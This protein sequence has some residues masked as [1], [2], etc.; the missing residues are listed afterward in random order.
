MTSFLVD[1]IEKESYYG[2]VEYKL[3]FFNMN[4]QKIK[5]YATQMK[6]RLIEGY[7][8]AVYLIGVRDN[9]QIVGLT[10]EEIDR[11]KKMLELIAKEIDS[12]VVNSVVINV[13]NSSQRILLANIKAEFD[14]NDILL[15]N[16]NI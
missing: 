3:N 4:D 6:F 2:N 9:G 13:E 5:K 14:L 10:K 12:K 15:L 7:G 1:N 16:D 11:S 8:E